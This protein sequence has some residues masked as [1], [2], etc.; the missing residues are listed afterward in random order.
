[1]EADS[2][3]AQTKEIFKAIAERADGDPGLGLSFER[4]YRLLQ[5]ATGVALANMNHQLR[6]ACL[7]LAAGHRINGH[8]PS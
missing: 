1:V 5:Q 3:L 7:R 8:E 6:L 2:S 4:T